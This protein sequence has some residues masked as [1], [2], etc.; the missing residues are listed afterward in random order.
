MRLADT[1]DI[2]ACN[3]LC[4]GVHGHHRSGELADAIDVESAYVVERGGRITGYTTGIAFGGHTVCET[5]DDVKA[6]IAHAPEYRGPG[7]FVPTGNAELLRWCYDHGLTMV[8]AVT[9]MSIGLY[10]QPQGAYLSSIIY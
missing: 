2:D 4:A 7:F 5:N 8:K 10:N 3:R 6:L 1:G 9:L